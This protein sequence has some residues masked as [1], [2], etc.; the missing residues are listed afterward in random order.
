MLLA[1]RL[2]ALLVAGVLGASLGAAQAAP[3]RSAD[4]HP[5]GYPTVE[6]VK[7]FGKLLAERSGGRLSVQVFHSRQ[8][9]DEKDTIEQTKI[10]AIDLNRVNLGPFNNIVPETTVPPL[11]FLFRSVAHMRK[12]MDGPIGDDILKAFE[13]HG[14][15]GLCFYDSGARSFYNRVKPIHSPADMK[16][17]KIRV[18]QS[19]LFV[20]VMQALGANATPMPFGEVY[21]G[22]KTGVIDGAENNWPSYD[23]ERH[24]EVAKYYTVNEHS[25]SP[26]VLV[27]SKIVWD[28]LPQADRDLIRK[29]AKDSVPY[30]RELWDAREK[31]SRDKVVAAGSEVVDPV[32]KRPFQEA[33]K[34]VYD[35]FVTSD[36]LKDLV[37][38]IQATPDS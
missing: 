3:F 19:D 26:E 23:S 38:R 7:Q 36:K 13:P 18:Q 1:K 20:A 32:D 11:P 4:T 28:K 14:F 37:A 30:M 8:L 31:K 17:M 12:A 33:M 6:G 5:D 10:G 16:G 21:T 34:P 27:M 9:G 24:F 35:R 15:I 25:M 2:A 22:L 29:A